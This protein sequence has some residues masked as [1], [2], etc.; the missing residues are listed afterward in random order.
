MSRT[1]HFQL[2]ILVSAAVLALFFCALWLPAQTTPFW[3]D[4]Y[5]FLSDAHAANMR[6]MPWWTPFWPEV[7]FKFWRPLSQETFWRLVDKLLAGDP[8]AA[9]ILNLGLLI[10]A[11]C[12]VGVLGVILAR[13]CEWPSAFWTGTLGALVYGSLSLHIL[14]VHWISAANSSI[15]VMWSALCLA[16]WLVAP[17]SNR[18]SR[19]VLWGLIPV[20]LIAALLSKESAVLLPLLMLVLTLFVGPR[21]RPGAA[22]W[23]VWFACSIIIA[24]WLALRSRFTTTADAEYALF[25]GPNL[26]RNAL[27]LVAWLLNIP[28]EG[29]RMVLSAEAV[30]AIAWTTAVL[31]PMLIA[32][33]IAF[34]SLSQE[35]NRQ[36]TLAA[37]AFVTL[38]YAPYLPL[39]WNSYAYYAAIAAILPALLL[40]RGLI[41]SR[42]T[43]VGTLLIGI[44]SLIAVEGTRWLDHP[45]LIG[46]AR[47]ANVTLSDLEKETITPPLFVLPADH[48][49]FYA[50]GAA[51]LAWRL[52]LNPQDVHVVSS[53]PDRTV[54]CLVIAADGQWFW[55][56]PH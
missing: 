20:L 48:Q 31:F 37:I 41:L 44:S 29:I 8:R 30:P 24:I 21:A 15:L 2:R 23:V 18:I 33:A 53:C 12:S 26:V 51:G 56:Q 45:G 19:I 28:R 1:T 4:D 10:L 50:I 11:A 9:H 46:R 47:W 55:K 13:T 42:F 34:R 27:S 6:G 7:Q 22:E 43:L 40:A 25:F 54:R 36:Q 52:G 5:V 35:I 16:A 14:P 49:R 17:Q 39:A 3:G 38:A 32:W